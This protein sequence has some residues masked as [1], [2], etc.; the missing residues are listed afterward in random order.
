LVILALLRKSTVKM[1][2]IQ[3]K[4]KVAA[5]AVLILAAST[6]LTSSGGASPA[7]DGANLVGNWTGDSICVGP[8]PA[9]R[10]EKVI[11]RI[12]KAPDAKGTVTI[13]ADKIVNG[14]PELMGVLDFKYDS[15]KNTLTCDFIRGN[16]HGLW[17]FSVKGDTMEGSLLVLPDK[18]LARRVKLKKET[19]T[20]TPAS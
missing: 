9:C 4:S 5:I 1:K 10:D 2:K 7:G 8:F 19:S 15:A 20:P 11:Y 16:T 12:P 6:L 3:P 17:E 13:T 18:T 14:K